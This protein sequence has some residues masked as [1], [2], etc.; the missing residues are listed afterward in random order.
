M[1]GIAGRLSSEI[2]LESEKIV[3]DIC[4]KMIHRGPD[5]GSVKSFGAM[6]MGHR[7]LSII[8]LSLEANQPMTL[9]TG[10]Y[11]I[12]FNGEI[13]N[14]QDIRNELIKIGYKFHTNSDTEVLLYSYQQWG[15]KCLTKFNGMFAFAIWDEIDQSLFLAR[16]RFGKKP[17]FYSIGNSTFTFA[18]ETIALLEDPSISNIFSHE[19]INCYLSLGYILNPMT[20]Y[21]SIKLLEPGSFMVISRDC[22]IVRKGFYW[23]YAGSFRTKIKASEE[24]IAKNILELLNESVKRRMISDVPVGAF[25]SGGIDSSSIVS[26]MKN[27]HKGDLHTFSVGFNQKSYNELPDAD[28]VGKWADT[29]HH[30]IIVDARQNDQI[31]EES[32]WASDQLFSDNSIIPMIEVSK[33]AAKQ[34]TV[35]LSGDGA[36]E[37]FGGY[38]TYTADNYYK[39]A[40]IV[41]KVIRQ[42]LGS[43]K[44][45]INPFSTKKINFDYRRQQFFSGTLFN[46]QKAHYSWRNIFNE[47]ERIKILGESSR[48]LVY[49]TD[50]FRVFKKYYDN[51]LDLESLDQH[52]YVD[53]MTWLTDDILVKV[54]RSTM[55]SSIEAR[56]PYLDIDLVNYAASIPSAIKMKNGIKKYILKKALKNTVPEFVL[57][58]KKN[59][60]NAPVN[61]WI[62]NTENNEFKV[63]NKYVYEKR[64]S[65]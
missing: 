53:A 26:L 46:Y 7:R 42:L 30:G 22:K 3:L 50:P 64:I 9:T 21:S 23:N 2:C 63:F 34:V 14:Y 19:A 54:D 27:F 15:E 40:Q 6:V 60:F 39:K 12:V 58:K 17:L 47:E 35:V 41:P 59:G 32:I 4:N 61:M 10:R 57:N 62:E 36:D 29:I 43:Q 16:D 13:Y 37:L 44:F 45:S 25:L 33:L 48:E 28:R 52:L 55:H 11:S 18:S 38:I 65:K 31:L 8:D 51:V 56:A 20:M 5:F 1:C 49:D 24:E